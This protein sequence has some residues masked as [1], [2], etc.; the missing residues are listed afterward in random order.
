MPERFR[1][2]KELADRTQ[3]CLPFVDGQ[4]V[5]GVF[6]AIMMGMQRIQGG[7]GSIIYPEILSP[8]EVDRLK[9]ILD[10]SNS[11]LVRRIEAIVSIKLEGQIATKIMIQE[12]KRR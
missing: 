11:G 7:S 8:R 6:K 10:R 3:G 1:Y 4:I 5:S 12:R 2:Q 9:R